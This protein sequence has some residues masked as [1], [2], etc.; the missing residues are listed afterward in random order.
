MHDWFTDSH[1]AFAQKVQTMTELY[2]EELNACAAGEQQCGSASSM[3]KGKGL[4]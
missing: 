2:A 4:K 1:E 3:T